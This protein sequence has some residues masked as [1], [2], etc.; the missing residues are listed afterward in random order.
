MKI[1]VD[2][3]A[4]E[5]EQERITNVEGMAVE[6]ATGMLFAEW[7]E[8]LTKGSMLAQTALVWIVKKRQQPTLRFDDV[9]YESLV[10]EDAEAEPAPKDDDEA[11]TA[12]A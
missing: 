11:S 10:V 3:E 8:A 2:G 9:V 12:T 1:L 4:F 6:R 7:A 5:F